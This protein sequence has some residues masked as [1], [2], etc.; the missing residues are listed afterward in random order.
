MNFQTKIIIFI[1]GLILFSI[2]ILTII[3]S[4]YFF[5]ALT[6]KGLSKMKK[7][8]LTFPYMLDDII[9]KFNNDSII[10]KYDCDYVAPIKFNLNIISEIH[11]CEDY[12]YV[13]SNKN[14]ILF[15]IPLKFLSEDD[16]N[17]FLNL[18]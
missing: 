17:K 2:A 1:L 11:E 14:N 18:F 5:Y 12:L 9:L 4:T 7:K 10:F 15:F 3:C 16:K 13:F 8:I 6:R